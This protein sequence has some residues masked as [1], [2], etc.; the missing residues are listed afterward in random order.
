MY[1]Y[2]QKVVLESANGQPQRMQIWGT[3]GVAAPAPNDA[4]Q[5][6]E[7]GYLY[8]EMPADPVAT[9]K[10]YNDLRSTFGK[11]GVVA[12]SGR[13]T[14]RRVHTSD[15]KPD[16]PDR[17]SF[18]NG[19]A[20]LPFGTDLPPVRKLGQL[21][22][23]RLPV[24]Y[25]LVDKVVVLPDT[26]APQ[27]IRIWGLFALGNAKDTSYTDA[28]PG[29]LS[30]AYPDDPAAVD[31]WQKLAGTAEVVRLDFSWNSELRLHTAGETPDASNVYNIKRLVPIRPDTLYPPVQALLAS[32]R[33]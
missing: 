31:A 1:G 14:S 22:K 20:V 9:L 26:G 23:G 28:R 21:P 16:R 33:R 3:F 24:A 6:P 27:S 18:G 13:E 29:Y 2:V 17:Y 4:Y 5:E 7:S 32:R 15:E 11:L 10:E 8:V 12:F 25:A 19:A 30:V